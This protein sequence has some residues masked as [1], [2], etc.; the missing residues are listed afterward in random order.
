M[1]AREQRVLRPEIC[2]CATRSVVL[3]TAIAA[4]ALLAVA[5][6]AAEATAAAEAAAAAAAAGTPV[7]TALPGT[8]DETVSRCIGTSKAATIQLVQAGRNERAPAVGCEQELQ[9]TA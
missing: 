9:S 7:T 4:A 6:A 2:I 3:T 5:A 1:T 8:R